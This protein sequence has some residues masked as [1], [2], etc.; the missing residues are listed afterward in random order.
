MP[1]LHPAILNAANEV[2]VQAFL[3]RELNF[4]G[5]AGVCEAVLSKMTGGAT[6]GP[7]RGLEDVLGADAESRRLARALIPTVLQACERGAHA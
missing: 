3:D 4:P 2:A 5:I 7:I 6:G 1:G